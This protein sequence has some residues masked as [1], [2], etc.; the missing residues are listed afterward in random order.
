MVKVHGVFLMTIE[1]TFALHDWFF[2]GFEFLLLQAAGVLVVRPAN[3]LPA[4]TATLVEGPRLH[5][6]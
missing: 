3:I 2:W 1:L 5:R 6:I 4:M